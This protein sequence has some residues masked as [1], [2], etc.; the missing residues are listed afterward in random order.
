MATKAWENT[1][2]EKQPTADYKRQKIAAT[3]TTGEYLNN[4]DTSMGGIKRDLHR[5]ALK[6]KAIVGSGDKVYYYHTEDSVVQLLRDIK[7]GTAT[8]LELFAQLKDV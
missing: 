8:S 7:T 4:A 6:N 1:T 2:K 5:S 3:P